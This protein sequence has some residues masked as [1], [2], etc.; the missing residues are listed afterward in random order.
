ME[1]TS[2][3]TKEE[4]TYLEKLFENEFKEAAFLTGCI[5][6]SQKHIIFPESPIDKTSDD[7]Q[8]KRDQDQETKKKDEATLNVPDDEQVELRRVKSLRSRIRSS[9]RESLKLVI[10][11]RPKSESFIQSR[12]FGRNI[13][14]VNFNKI[15]EREE[16]PKKLERSV[17]SKGKSDNDSLEV[18]PEPEAVLQTHPPAPLLVEDPPSTDDE[19]LNEVRNCNPT[20]LHGEGHTQYPQKINVWAGILGNTVLCP[21][22]LNENLTGRFT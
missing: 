18:T 4:Y 10:N 17:S 15:E 3:S 20:F 21:I 6:Q 16:L 12:S 19:G 14:P 1:Q 11:I 13:S 8:E 2:D 7:E 22:F 9:V 5:E